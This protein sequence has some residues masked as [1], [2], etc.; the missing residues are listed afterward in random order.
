MLT[1]SV[2]VDPGAGWFPHYVGFASEQG[3]GAGSGANRNLCLAPES[4]DEP[5]LDAVAELA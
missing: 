5:W 1:G 4:G 2:H 3:A